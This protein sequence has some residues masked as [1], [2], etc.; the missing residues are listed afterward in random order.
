M[1]YA[2]ALILLAAT[3]SSAEVQEPPSDTVIFTRAELQEFQAMLETLVQQREKAAYE[4]GRA[5]A[6]QRCASLI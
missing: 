6:R 4:A 3:V 5:D 1:R 2:L